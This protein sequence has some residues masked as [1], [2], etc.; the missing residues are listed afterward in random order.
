MA[1][2]ESRFQ[3]LLAPFFRNDLP[4]AQLKSSA[5]AMSAYLQS[6]IRDAANALTT[7]R[8]VR[9]QLEDAMAGAIHEQAS[10]QARTASGARP[11]R[12]AD[13]FAE[14]APVPFPV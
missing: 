7:A 14:A 2:T 1:D 8:K 4:P 11:R 10:A 5:D 9:A 6:Q 3:Q 12:A 13:V